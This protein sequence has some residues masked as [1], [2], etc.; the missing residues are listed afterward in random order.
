LEFFLSKKCVLRIFSDGLISSKFGTLS[1][2]KVNGSGGKG[3]PGHSKQ[4]VRNA[5]WKIEGKSARFLMM[6]TGYFSSLFF[7]L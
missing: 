7:L 6:T 3:Q 5:S 1:Q 2:T 4:G